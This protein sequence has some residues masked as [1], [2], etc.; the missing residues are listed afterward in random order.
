M[1]PVIRI[2]GTTTG[3]WHRGAVTFGGVSYDTILERSAVDPRVEMVDVKDGELGVYVPN[4]SGAL[5]SLRDS[6]PA[7]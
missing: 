1:S 4:S 6:T 3:C 7:M 5:L 2:G